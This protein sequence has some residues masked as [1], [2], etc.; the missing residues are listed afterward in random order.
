MAVGAVTKRLMIHDV[1]RGAKEATASKAIETMTPNFRGRCRSV[2]E[3]ASIVVVANQHVLDI[4]WRW[5]T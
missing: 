4:Q 2:D 1:M 3:T 5:S